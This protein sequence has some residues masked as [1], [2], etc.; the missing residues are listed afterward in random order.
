[1]NRNPF[2]SPNLVLNWPR[3]CK[4]RVLPWLLQ[5]PVKQHHQLLFS[6]MQIRTESHLKSILKSLLLLFPTIM[7]SDI[8]IFSPKGPHYIESIANTGEPFP[9]GAKQRDQ[10]V[11]LAIATVQMKDEIGWKV[12]NF[13]K[14]SHDPSNS[15][16]S[17]CFACF[18]PDVV[19]ILPLKIS[20]RKFKSQKQLLQ[21]R[22]EILLIMNHHGTRH[23]V[24][25]NAGACIVSTHDVVRRKESRD[26]NIFYQEGLL[27]LIPDV[28]SSRALE[29]A[30]EVCDTN[31][32]NTPRIRCNYY[33]AWILGNSILAFIF[34]IF[35]TKGTQ[36]IKLIANI[37]EPF[38]TGAKQRD[39][40]DCGN[41]ASHYIELS[42]QKKQS[43]Q[44]SMIQ[45][46]VGGS[47]L[48][49][50]HSSVD[51]DFGSDL[52]S[53]SG[54]KLNR[55]HFRLCTPGVP[56]NKEYWK[57]TDAD[58]SSWKE[59][60]NHI[61]IVQGCRDPVGINSCY[62]AYHTSLN[63]DNVITLVVEGS[64][65]LSIGIWNTSPT[66]VSS[67]TQDRKSGCPLLEGSHVYLP[68]H[69]LEP[70]FTPELAEVG[71]LPSFV[72]TRMTHPA[73][74]TI[75]LAMGSRRQPLSKLPRFTQRMYG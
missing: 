73:N 48:E 13:W 54:R 63:Y 3:Y 40:T 8:T 72:I 57:H 46:W 58:I 52:C 19:N 1:M 44:V 27:Y 2:E 34:A 25:V 5:R 36:D 20:L 56:C 7:A 75:S 12:I 65:R 49:A 39:Q 43:T 29:G 26:N 42:R 18:M 21:L 62:A 47:F 61:S 66:D 23:Y 51:Y 68:S 11:I 22:P 30:L 41:L 71:L 53:D 60:G 50:R 16:H 74:D 31:C 55:V 38:P 45:R 4:N 24:D 32:G 70:H 37:N 15:W 14:E 33:R 17:A 67:A 6:N 28:G 59:S 69:I 35:F 9:T 64:L 10:V